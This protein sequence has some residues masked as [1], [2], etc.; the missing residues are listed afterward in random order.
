M[1]LPC[2]FLWS[3]SQQAEV[4]NRS[5]AEG[6]VKSHGKAIFAKMSV[7]SRTEA[8]AEA[9]RCGLIRL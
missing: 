9:T 6:T 3:P 1:V 7:V 8:V 4:G 5:L 2:A